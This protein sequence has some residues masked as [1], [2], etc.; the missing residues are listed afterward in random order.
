MLFIISFQRFLL[1]GINSQPK[2]FQ[3]WMCREPLPVCLLKSLGLMSSW[4]CSSN[5]GLCAITQWRGSL[6]KQQWSDFTWFGEDCG[7][8][9]G[10]WLPAFSAGYPRVLDDTAFLFLLLGIFLNY[11]QNSRRSIVFALLRE[12]ILGNL[13]LCNWRIIGLLR[14]ESAL[15]MKYLLNFINT[16]L[17]NWWACWKI[18]SF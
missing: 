5:A 7:H 2:S 15:I 13:N 8:H 6:G 10:Y 16:I 11:Y 9:L 4:S 17:Y 3:C 12:I 18:F 14:N 1:I